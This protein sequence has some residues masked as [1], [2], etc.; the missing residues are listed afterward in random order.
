MQITQLF[1]M[2]NT[3]ILRQVDE[4]QEFWVAQNPESLGFCARI[5]KVRQINQYTID[6]LQ[7]WAFKP[8]QSF[9]TGFQLY[10]DM[11]IVGVAR[12]FICLK[13]IFNDD[14]FFTRYYFSSGTIDLARICQGN[15]YGYLILYFGSHFCT[16]VF[17]LF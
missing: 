10:F 16:T 1:Y 15:S 14:L 12:F 3:E 6:R 2:F 5:L 11:Y 7:I 8:S 17:I 13:V 9:C 4:F